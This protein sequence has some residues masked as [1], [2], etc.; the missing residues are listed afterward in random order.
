MK[1]DG[2]Q[3][4]IE[5]RSMRETRQIEASLVEDDGSG[6]GCPSSLLPTVHE[7]ATELTDRKAPPRST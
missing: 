3:R 6:G 4:E 7:L 2:G 5:P 1:E